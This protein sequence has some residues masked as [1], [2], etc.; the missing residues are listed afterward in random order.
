MY[1]VSG[2]PLS[3]LALVKRSQLV[4]AGARRALPA[5]AREA[6]PTL[7]LDR[8]YGETRVV[9]SAAPA[10]GGAAR[11]RP[12]A[13]ASRRPSSRGGGA[14]T[15]PA[16]GS[17]TVHRARRSRRARPSDPALT[18]AESRR[19]VS[20]STS[21]KRWCRSPASAPTPK[22]VGQESAPAMMRSASLALNHGSSSRSRSLGTPP[23]AATFASASASRSCRGAG[24]RTE[25]EARRGDDGWGDGA[26]T[27]SRR[28]HSPCRSR[29]GCRRGPSPPC[30]S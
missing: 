21:A 20:A 17:G 5:G 15:K 3:R 9:G 16:L 7:A 28:A 13:V 10:L 12:G 29:G 26:R 1:G 6:L 2:H 11:R 22:C 14:R 30:E 23:M 19:S 18:R 4:P 24:E 27:T 8:S 25:S